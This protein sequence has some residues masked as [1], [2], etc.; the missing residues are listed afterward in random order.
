MSLMNKIKRLNRIFRVRGRNFLTVSDQVADAKILAAKVLLNQLGDRGV[1]ADIHEAEFKVFSQFG[2]DGIIQYLIR[3]VG[4]LDHSTFI[5]FGVENY[6][7]A[8]TR[9]LLVNNNW[10]GLILDGAPQ[11]IAHVRD[12]RLFWNHNLTAAASF[13]DAEN[14]DALIVQNGFAGKEIGL[15]SIDIDGNDY[16]VWEK[17]SVIEPVIVIAEFNSVF[18]CSHAITVPYDPKFVRSHAHSSYLYF[19]ASLKA[20][21]LLGRRKGYELVGCNSA[22]NNAFF[23]RQDRL[24]G[25][26][27]LSVEDAYVESQFRESRDEFGNPTFMAGAARLELIKNMPVYD[28]ERNVITKI[29]DLALI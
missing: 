14:I 19:G 28:V 8:N 23:V 5:E 21:E 9:F 12:T 3:Q 16:W 2:E 13:I 27:V 6:E 22:G 18:G 17:I 10:R 7:E 1:L 29:A 4:G 20:L 26:P 24:N 15:L 11:N 25:L